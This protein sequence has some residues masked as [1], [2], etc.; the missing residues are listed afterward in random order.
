MS[1]TTEM[2]SIV[3]QGSD[4]DFGLWQFRPLDELGLKEQDL[5][6]AIL[7]QPK[8]LVV[9]PLDLLAGKIA[10]Y[11]QSNLSFRGSRRR[12]DVVIVTDHGDV[13]VVEAK[14]LI[15][16]EL[17]DGRQAIAQVVEYATL[18]SSASEADLVRS[19]TKEKHSSWNLLC[20]HDLGDSGD[21]NRLAN[22]VRNRVKDGEIHLVIACDQAPS[23]LADLVRAATNSKA[24]AF[25]LH[26]IEVR[27]MVPAG[28]SDAEDCPIGWVPWPRLDTEIVHR[29]SVTVRTEGFDDDGSPSIRVDIQNDSGREVEEKVANSSRASRTHRERVLEVQ[30][31]LTPVAKRLG[32]TVEH[33]W[34]EI[35][36]LNRAV[37]GEDWSGLKQAIA[38]ADDGGPNQRKGNIS[39]GRY[40][41]NLLTIWRPSVFIGAYLRDHDHKQSLLAPHRGGDFA[42]IVD[43]WGKAKEREEFANHPCF[44]ALRER[45]RGDAGDWDFADHH[46]QADRNSW[47]PLHLRRPLQEVLGDTET[48]EERKARWL[49]AAHDAVEILLQGGELAGLHRQIQRE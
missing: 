26:V 20:R 8:A 24:L 7:A 11:A 17:R 25:A 1:D 16:A 42:L 19:L 13:I 45:L 4:G 3:V 46:N 39:W 27:P 32:L 35:T 22:I 33:L 49:T 44:H 47:H 6:K 30:Q 10:A 41:V 31:V 18:L 36:E 38:H 34:E 14:R 15:N 5:E 40:G 37:E 29:T 43:V 23:D 2:N 9:D 48:F 28:L 12:P 21:S